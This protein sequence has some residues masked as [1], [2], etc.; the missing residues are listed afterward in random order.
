VLDQAWCVWDV[1]LHAGACVQWGVLVPA[2]GL[3]R[4]RIR[5]CS[6]YSSPCCCV[7]MEGFLTDWQLDWQRTGGIMLFQPST[8]LQLCTAG[9]VMSVQ[10]PQGG[11]S[12][13]CPVCVGR[14]VVPG[15]LL[16]SSCVLAL[17]RC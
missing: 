14:V 9:L 13:G 12:C 16:G 10:H 6:P 2:C 5:A 11:V 7:S 3:T 4:A 15:H 8:P 17:V 1:C